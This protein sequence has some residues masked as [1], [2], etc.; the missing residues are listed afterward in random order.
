MEDEDGQNEWKKNCGEKGDEKKRR[1][2]AGKKAK[3]K[4][5]S[6]F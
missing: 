3:R 4:K 6:R 1:G 2:Y 5:G